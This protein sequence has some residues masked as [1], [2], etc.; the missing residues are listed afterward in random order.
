M[1]HTYA[2]GEQPRADSAPAAADLAALVRPFLPHVRG[3]NETSIN[4]VTALKDLRRLAW[5]TTAAKRS[6]QATGEAPMA[7]G[8]SAVT[9]SPFAIRTFVA[10]TT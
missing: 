2:K 5:N 1:L 6:P 10:K 9:L 3:F 4:G 7:D 8:G